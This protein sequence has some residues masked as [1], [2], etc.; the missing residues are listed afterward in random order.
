MCR[1]IEIRICQY[2]TGFSLEHLDPTNGGIMAMILLDGI[3]L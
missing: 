3:I 2:D 1:G